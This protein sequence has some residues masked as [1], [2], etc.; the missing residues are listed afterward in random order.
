MPTQI[1]II[2]LGQIGASIGMALKEKKSTVQR[3]GFDKDPAVARGAE[4]LGAVD[5]LKNPR[6]AVKDADIV[7]LCLPLSQM[8]ETLKL[9]GPRLKEGAI[10][11]DTAPIKSPMTKW[12]KEFIPAGRFYIGLVPSLSAEALSSSEIGLKAA[13]PDLFKSTIMAIDAPP[14][15]PAEVEQ[16]AVALAQLLGAKP[17]LT[18]LQESDG[19]MATAHLLPQLAAAALLD[20][21]VDQPGWADWRKL[22]GRPYL[23]VTGGIAYYD[24]P[25]SLGTA[26][27]ENPAAVTRALD[28]LIVSLQRLRDA[29]VKRD[30]VEVMER[31]QWAFD[32]RERWLDERG[33]QIG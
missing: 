28:S 6:E 16:F 5:N 32:C 14:D 31:L 11:V 25:A 7:L 27:L 24:D 23:S 29:V 18:D 19:L 15:T 26:A 4:T 22:A 8:H 33:G 9:I 17:M 10:V 30:A 2:G 1:T 3:V 20:A 21:T 13:R 12:A